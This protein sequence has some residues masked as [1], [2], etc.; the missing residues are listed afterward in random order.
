MKKHRN[1]SSLINIKCQQQQQQLQINKDDNNINNNNN[2]NN[3]KNANN[4]NN[5]KSKRSFYEL[6]SLSLVLSLWCL[7]FLFYSRLGLSHENAGNLLAHSKN[8]PAQGIRRS[9]TIHDNEASS[10][11]KTERN[12]FTNGMLL[13]HN[14]SRTCCNNSV[15]NPHFSNYK[16]SLRETLRLEEVFLRMLGHRDLVCEIRQR[17]HNATRPAKDRTPHSP[18]LNFDE[19]RNISRQ[20]KDLSTPNR[21]L[22]ITHRLE[23][24]GTEYNYASATKGAKV[25]SHNKEAKGASNIL[26]KDHDKYLR[27]P[28][29]VGGKYVVIELSEETLVDAVQIVNFEHYSSNFKEFELFGSLSYPTETWTPLGRFVAANVKHIQSF[30]MPEPKSVRYLKLDLLSHYGKEFYCTLSVVEVYGVDA[31]KQMLEDLFVAKEKTPTPKKLP[32]PNSTV[33]SSA[34]PDLA[35]TESKENGG[36]PQLGDD[37]E[38]GNFDDAPKLKEDGKSPITIGSI[39]DPVNDVRQQSIGRIPGD[40]VLKILMQK[41]RS[42]ELNLSVLEEYI[43]ELNKRQG[44]V[45]PELD[46]EL[47]KIVSVLERS[48]TEI[49]DLLG[50]K[51]KMK[52]GISDLDSWKAS[53][54]SRIEMLEK[55]NSMLRLDIEK[56][57]ND[58]E[59]LET[60]ELA[61]LAVSLFFACFAILKLASVGISAVAGVCQSEKVCRTSKGWV[62]ILISS[63][64]TIFI[65]LLSG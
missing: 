5:A 59:N 3:N 6:S 2:N 31:I 61:V 35:C 44:E 41:V 60:K 40:T 54:S 53:V 25:V 1:C 32:K 8:I 51:E 15:I 58:Q 56:V 28:C 19:F 57:A 39:P 24:D 7:L 64:M 11:V 17:D 18:Y 14:N 46:K 16:F 48:R 49:S 43:K 34:N 50:W 27:N 13:G 52:K 38:T 22:K 55:V 23:P 26:G 10:L 20:E 63:S 45:L 21:L 47:S 9:S 33:I 65:T 4:A 37:I 36:K 62:W 29:S 12:N 30:N 42:L